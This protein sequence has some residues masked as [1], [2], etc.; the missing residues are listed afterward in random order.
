MFPLPLHIYFEIAALFVSIICWRSLSKN[1]LRWF[2]PFLLFIVIIELT[3]RYLSYEMRQ[4]NAWLFS[5]S[6]PF[7]YCFYALIFWFAFATTQF[8]KIALAFVV[9]FL[10]YNI[11][12]IIFITG[13]KF[14]DM[15]VLVA[16]NLAMVVL[17]I[18]YFVELYNANDTEPVLKNS[19]FWIIT[20]IFLFNGGEF[21]YN[22]LTI[23]I[24]DERFDATLKIFRSINNSLILVLYSCFIIGFICQ[25]ISGTYK[26]A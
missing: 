6:I 5:L 18:F 2:L 8:K 24:T 22:L 21:F 20:G 17:S 25:K 23:L 11:Y 1:G 15:N 3:A 13:L 14:F 10:L 7:E 12:S 26:K 19:L 16:G 9:G 4:P